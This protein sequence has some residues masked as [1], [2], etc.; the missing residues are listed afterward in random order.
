[1]SF[2]CTHTLCQFINEFRKDIVKYTNKIVQS[3][4]LWQNKFYISF[5]NNTKTLQNDKY[6][7]RLYIRMYILYIVYPPKHRPSIYHT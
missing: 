4:R 7:L 1:M 5:S 3:V 6:L 2:K